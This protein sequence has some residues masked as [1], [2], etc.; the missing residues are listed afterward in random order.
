MK[1]RRESGWKGIKIRSDC[2]V[3]GLEGLE[4]CHSA[5]R[6]PDEPLS[7]TVKVAPSKAGPRTGMDKTF[8]THISDCNHGFAVALLLGTDHHENSCTCEK[9]PPSP[10][11]Y[12]L[13]LHLR[14]KKPPIAKNHRILLSFIPSS[15]HPKFDMHR[16]PIT[17][18]RRGA[19]MTSASPPHANNSDA[20]PASSLP[21]PGPQKHGKAVTR[22]QGLEIWFSMSLHVNVNNLNLYRPS[23]ST[24]PD[25]PRYASLWCLSGVLI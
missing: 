3:S 19:S 2:Q 8:E 17:E 18:F 24:Y 5:T 11:N 25:R 23:V 10:L 15:R 7:P 13:V 14:S 6:S 16:T 20:D 1:R 22:F 12:P 21:E 4:E 9:S